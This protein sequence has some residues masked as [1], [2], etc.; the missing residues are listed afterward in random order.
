MT[1]LFTQPGQLNTPVLF[2]VFNRPDTTARVFETIRQAKPLRLYVASDGPRKDRVGEVDQVEKTRGIATAVDWPC[3]VTTLF[4]S[5]NL[6]CKNAVSEA[7]NWFF[8]H[9]E[10]G[11]ILEDD[12]LP[13]EGFFDYCQAA[14]QKYCDNPNVGIVT[15][16][17]LETM[18]GNS[19]DR[20]MTKFTSYG[21]IWGWATWRNIWNKYDVELADW[22]PA[23]VDFLRGKYSAS[24]LYVHVW[25]QIFTNAKNGKTDTWCHQLNFML[26]R[27]NLLCV[28][29]PYNL[30]DNIGYGCAATHT[31]ENR[32]AWLVNSNRIIADNIT[33]TKPAINLALDRA[34]GAKIFGIT[35]W[36][37]I[38]HFIKRQ[39]RYGDSHL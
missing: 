36:A 9:E 21:L 20:Y 27:H 33:F 17:S 11:I 14:L 29:P 39:I 13:A 19:N 1:E 23:D 31:V 22:D 24:K 2:L 10:S 34:I 26:L 35:L 30:I 15:G 32:P 3:K 12:V 7:I 37:K 25:H 38:K 18:A 8:Q 4:R 5:H 6:G 16:H 28:H